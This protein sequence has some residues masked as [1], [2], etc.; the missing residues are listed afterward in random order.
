MI[1]LAPAA[2]IELDPALSPAE[3]LKTVQGLM[4]EDHA[5]AAKI[6]ASITPAYFIISGREA[7]A[8]DWPTR[9]NFSSGRVS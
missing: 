2:G 1:K 5:G 4:A 9:R 8:M 3:K 7:A 6:Y